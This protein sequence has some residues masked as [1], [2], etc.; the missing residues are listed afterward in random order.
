MKLHESDLAI[1]TCGSLNMCV[2]C[3]MLR[4]AMGGMCMWRET[5]GVSETT[6]RRIW[7]RANKCIII[8]SVLLVSWSEAGAQA[9]RRLGIRVNR[10]ILRRK[11]CTRIHNGTRRRANYKGKTCH[12]KSLYRQSPFPTS[13]HGPHF[14]PSMSNCK[15][16]PSW[17]QFQFRRIWFGV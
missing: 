17:E 15:S 9:K 6:A 10:T 5:S 1:Y 3:E 8:R 12:R 7:I 4:V 11:C 16:I 13:L 14:G 2:A